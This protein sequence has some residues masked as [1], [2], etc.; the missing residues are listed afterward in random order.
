MCTKAESRGD[1]IKGDTMLSKVVGRDYNNNEERIIE[2][3]TSK[4]GTEAASNSG[5]LAF[6]HGLL[7][8]F[9]N[10]FIALLPNLSLSE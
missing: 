3:R 1:N 9:H 10:L 8:H 7:F 5:L 6:I 4:G 2:M